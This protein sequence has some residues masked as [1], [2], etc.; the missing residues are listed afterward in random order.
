MFWICWNQIIGTLLTSGL[1]YDV[2]LIV[3]KCFEIMLI[4]VNI[5]MFPY[6]L[7]ISIDQLLL[8]H[9]HLPCSFFPTNIYALY[10]PKL[11]IYINGFMH[12]LEDPVYVLINNVRLRTGQAAFRAFKPW[13]L[14]RIRGLQSFILLT[15]YFHIL[16]Y[17]LYPLFSNRINHVY[18]DFA[19]SVFWFHLN[20]YH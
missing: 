10:S 6:S 19:E 12:F 4:Y 17:C 9:V 13:G 18:F 3:N 16:S 2:G 11:N 15:L 8:S 14:N 5:K 1:R 7:G 20:L